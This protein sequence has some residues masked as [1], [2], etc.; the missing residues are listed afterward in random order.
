MSAML[1]YVSLGLDS[2]AVC[3]GLGAIRSSRRAWFRIALAFGLADGS[4][5]AFGSFLLGRDASLPSAL[6]YLAPIALVIYGVLIA[7]ATARVRSIVSTRAGL[8][9][10]PLL[11]S[12]DNVMAAALGETGAVTAASILSSVVTTGIMALLG[13][14]AGATLSRMWPRLRRVLPGAAPIAA[15]LVMSFA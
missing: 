15:A 14:V 7:V 1:A 10:L 12:F 4:G 3:I 8:V 9:T 2:F 13:C 11:L 5:T 6:A